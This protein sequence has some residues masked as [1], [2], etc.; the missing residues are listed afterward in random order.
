MGN[1]WKGK[2]IKIDDYRFM[3]PEDYKPGMRVPGIIFADEKLLK[4]ILSDQSPEQVANVA[5]L[6]GIIY[7]SLAM[8][9]IHW[10]YG[11]PIGGVAAMR[12]KGGVIS[13]G[14]VGYD[15]NCGVR[16]IRT[17]LTKEEVEPKIKELVDELFYAIPAG[18][19]S[20]GE[21]RI[22][23]KELDEVLAN[24]ARWAVK[25]GYGSKED[26]NRIEEGGCLR[27]ANPDK[28]SKKAKERGES[29][30]GTLGSGNHF[31][32]VQ[33]VSRVFEPEIAEKIGIFEGQI[34]IMIHTG[35]R[36]LGHQVA[37]D[38]IRVMNSAMN[39]YGI[40][41]PD[42]QL[43]CAPFESPE[44]QD[45]F[46]AMCAAAN[47]AWANRQMITHW[48]RETMEK[49]FRMGAEKLGLQLVYDVA[50]NIAKL[51]EHI[52]EGKKEEVIVHRKGA[53]RAFPSGHPEIP[54]EYKDIGQPV[55]IPG[56][57]GR[58][59]FLLVGLPKAMEISFG[60]TCHGAGRTQSRSELLR[61]GRSASD[62]EKEL[63]ERGIIV[64]A[65]S[66][67]SIVEEAS[68]AYKNVVDVVNVVHNAGISL[69]VAQM[70]PLAVIKG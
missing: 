32:E 38:Y 49:V 7:A 21:L 65:A 22:K 68:E 51:E 16:L 69:R 25:K 27:Y 3:I 40:N 57:M 39:K 4:D 13:P 31:L 63:L 58:S 35:S 11:F 46:Q 61:S 9:D 60:S 70:K 42:R 41:V 1:E 28:V 64:R 19:G 34:V 33:V 48:V 15:I 52:V 55:I 43:A 23:G 36:G 37:E 2:I 44:G 67:K 14:G 29:Q 56:D 45:Y 20:E 47:F 53:T 50:H 54:E 17:N 30:L 8:P 6:P 5:T 26:L 62:I 59:S 10:G 18:V 24:G 66:K 12:R